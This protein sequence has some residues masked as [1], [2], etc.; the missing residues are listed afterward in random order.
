MTGKRIIKQELETGEGYCFATDSRTVRI[1]THL[2][3]EAHYSR[4]RFTLDIPLPA[5]VAFTQELQEDLAIAI[6]DAAIQIM[7]E[8]GL[9]P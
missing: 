6:T 1:L 5:D 7:I 2:S 8:K 4:T 9:L 3:S